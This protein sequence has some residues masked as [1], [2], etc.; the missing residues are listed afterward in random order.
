MQP[1]PHQTTAQTAENTAMPDPTLL[2]P[3][4]FVF[5]GALAALLGAIP[6]IH[7]RL[8]PPRM[9]ALLALAPMAAFVAL[10][11][12]VPWLQTSLVLTWQTPW[13]RSI[14]MPMGLYVDSLSAFFA[15]L[16]TFIGTLV[17][18]YSGQY[19]KNDTGVWRFLCY[20]LLF[21]AAML[22]LVM[23]GDVLTLFIFWEGTSI[24]SFLLVAY[25]GR[26]AA[27]R[28]GAFKALFVT[29]GGGIALLMG[30]LLIA[31][32]VGDSRLMIILTSGDLLRD[33]PLYP[34]LLALVALG[35]FTKSAQFPFHI[36]LPDAMS[37]PT[38][39][40][41]YLHSATMVKA[42]IYLMARLNPV[43]GFTEA[44]FWLLTLA[45][46]ATMLTG[47][48][49]ALRKTDLKA[50]LAY[51]TVCQ[52][53]ILMMM[54]GQDMEISFKALVI[55][56]LA[57]ALYKSAL[58]LVAG[59][60]DHETGTRDIDRLGG[61]RRS[62]PFTFVIGA[63]A[64]LS[65]AGLPPLF[66]FLAKET[67]LATAVHPSLPD[68]V[69]WGLVAASVLTGALMLA[70][71]ARLVWDTFLGSACDPGIR[72][73]EAPPLMLLAP[74]IPAALSVVLGQLPGPKQEAVLL[75]NAAGAAYG[76]QVT[77]SLALWHGLNIPLLLSVVAIGVGAVIFAK[78][79]VVIAWLKG[80][81]WTT[82]LNALYDTLLA[83]IDAAAAAATRLQHGRLR[84]YLVTMLAAALALVVGFGGF[85]PDVDM[86]RLTRPAFS[87][88]GELVLLRLVALF[89][90][91]GS[92][93]ASVV[94]TKDFAAILAFGAAGLGIAVLMALAPA[95][96]VALV[97]IVVDILLVVILV[98]ALSRLPAEQLRAVEKR[99]LGRRTGIWRDALISGAFGIVVMAMALAAVL[100][101]PRTTLL[102]P[103][104]EAKAKPA[105]GSN[106]IVGAII[107]DFRGIDTLVEIV[108]F[109]IAGIGIAALLCLAA[110]KCGFYA[111]SAGDD[112][113]RR[114]RQSPT[115]GIGGPRSAPLI[116]GLAH[117]TLPLAMIV[118]ATD[119]LFGHD[120]PGDGFTAGVI[121]GIGIGFWYVV[122]GYH[123]TRRR[124][125][126]LK[127]SAFIGWGVLLAIASGLIGAGIN[128]HF[129]SN[130]DIGRILSLPLPKGIHLSTSVLFEAAIFLSVLGS[131]THMLNTLGHP[132]EGGD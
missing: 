55:G 67:L 8:T 63:V 84:I 35:A 3:I 96:D 44:W 48:V 25:K 64:A 102:T 90:I 30:L 99:G 81:Q 18:I 108:V 115:L 10:V 114:D 9:A 78:R 45:G 16:V 75:A 42:G 7:R 52:L 50:I 113:P 26:D 54:I 74:A 15:L 129:F 33:S 2:L 128:G 83:A 4:L 49:V 32:V 73:H 47:A 80:I 88:D 27:A 38:P 70:I 116:R 120:T 82:S 72:G 126:W 1:V 34:L 5:A 57:H 76:S 60:V 22:G 97:Q 93:L 28:K 62:M 53:G 119:L 131:V 91:V 94:L 59:I 100:S 58:F 6:A 87:F 37:A 107:T 89:L 109:S 46:L 56:V 71:A 125:P 21:M 20:L 117:V 110:G 31:H 19:F 86:G 118:G 101:R 61:L 98:L 104:F 12:K 92:A 39:A 66:G 130:V 13:L 43:L 79:R 36:W 77:V 122:F 40:S 41:A 123:E 105:A 14:G 69:A 106:S 68:V 24:T 95:P 65:M 17:V 112:D 127:P 132:E 11:L 23:A 121:V 111:D 29:G 85:P 51:S 103:F 124:L